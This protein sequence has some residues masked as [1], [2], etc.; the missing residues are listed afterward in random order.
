[1]LALVLTGCAGTE[2]ESDGDAAATSSTQSSSSSA[3]GTGSSSAAPETPAG[4]QLAVT[5]AGGEASGDTGRVPVGLGEQVTLTVTSDAPDE[6]HLHGYDLTAQL[7]PGEPASLTFTA[8][9]AGVFEAELHDA[10][11]VLLSLQVG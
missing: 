8:D 4:T 6:L 10:G 7:A 11:T 2:P 9:I 1:M 5:V 3:G